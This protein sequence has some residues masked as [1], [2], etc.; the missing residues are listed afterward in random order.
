MWIILALGASLM[1]GLNYVI[2]EQ[3]YKKISVVT[4]LAITTVITGIIMFIIAYAGGFLQKDLGAISSSRRLLF[5]VVAETVILILAE[6][7]IGFSITAKSA[8]LAGLIEISY[9]IFIAIFAYLL[10]KENQLN[11]PTAIGGAFI[12]IGVF[13]IYYFNK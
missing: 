13:I 7:F 12:F 1:W 8:T 9:P 3:I 2:G 4:S 10:F 11:V 6:L 5:L